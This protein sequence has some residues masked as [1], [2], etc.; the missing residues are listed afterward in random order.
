MII[1]II[2]FDEND[3]IR[4]II[5]IYFPLHDQFIFHQVPGIWPCNLQPYKNAQAKFLLLL[6]FLFSKGVLGMLESH[7]VLEL[8]LLL[9]QDTFTHQ[10]SILFHLVKRLPHNSSDLTP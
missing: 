2:I 8:Y 9:F 10:L 6:Q 5:L 1:K 7:H 4:A 3:S